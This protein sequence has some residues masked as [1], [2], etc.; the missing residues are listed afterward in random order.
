MA[1]TMADKVF[2][3]DTVGTAEETLY[4]GTAG[5][6]IKIIFICNVTTSDATLQLWRVDNAGSSGDTNKILNSVT[7]P[8]NDF[9]QINTYMPLDVT[10]DFI[11][12]DCSVNNAV[13]VTLMGAA[14]T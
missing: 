13:C 4:T 6:V 12:A 7:I 14:I 11:R 2:S 9:M 1:T 10:G 3:S 5:D 8:A